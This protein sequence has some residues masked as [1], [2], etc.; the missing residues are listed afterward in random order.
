MAGINPFSNRAHFEKTAL[1]YVEDILLVP[2]I[3]PAAAKLLSSYLGAGNVPIH[4]TSDLLAQFG[5]FFQPETGKTA[6]ENT[7]FVWL[8]AERGITHSRHDITHAMSHKFQQLFPDIYI[9]HE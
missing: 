7:F 4:T 8:K 5:A 2:G 9:E 1:Q 3:G 6:H